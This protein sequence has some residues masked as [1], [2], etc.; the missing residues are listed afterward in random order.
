VASD[1]CGA[2]ISGSGGGG[3]DERQTSPRYIAKTVWARVSPWSV[4]AVGIWASTGTWLFLPSNQW[5]NN[6]PSFSLNRI[7][8]KATLNT[9]IIYKFLTKNL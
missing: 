4:D 2:E 9:Q 5:V 7:P 3:V 6:W 8:T 1:D